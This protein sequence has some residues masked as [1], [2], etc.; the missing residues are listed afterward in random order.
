MVG[1]AGKGPTSSRWSQQ[2]VWNMLTRN[3]LT[4]HMLIRNMLTRN[5][6]TRNMLLLK[7]LIGPKVIESVEYLGQARRVPAKSRHLPASVKSHWMLGRGGKGNRDRGLTVVNPY[8]P[9]FTA[10]SLFARVTWMDARFC[11]W[12]RLA[13]ASFSYIIY[14]LARPLLS[15][16]LTHFVMIVVGSKR[17]L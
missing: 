14:G 7:F 12:D 3:M 4:R 8:L 1:H 9:D 2:W 10:L 11:T 16:A 5:M 13:A 15:W 17:K 6:L